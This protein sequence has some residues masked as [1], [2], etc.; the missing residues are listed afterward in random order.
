MLP[1]IERVLSDWLAAGATGMG[2][3]EIRKI[4]DG[5]VLSHHEDAARTDIKIFSSPNDATELAKFD[6]EGTYRPLKTAPNLRHGWKLELK[7]VSELGR[8]LDLFYPGRLA[9][10]SVWEANRLKTTA[11]RETLNRQSGI[12]RVAAKISDQQIDVLVGRFCK[13]HGGAPGCLRTI[14]WPRDGSNARPSLRLPLDKFIAPI[15]QTGR[16]EK[17]MPLLC[18]EAC[19]LLIASARETVR[20]E[21]RQKS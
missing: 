1:R 17:V 19:N 5:F 6:D 8:A 18:Q 3:I 16:E 15:D 21:S 12:Y 14:L 2:Q 11:L 4:G 10:L 20:S 13:S 7:N 9:T